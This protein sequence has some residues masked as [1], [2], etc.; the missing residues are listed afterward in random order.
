MRARRISL[1]ASRLVLL[2]S[3]DGAAR[4]A[5][6]LTIG[7]AQGPDLWGML[8]MPPRIRRRLPLVGSNQILY[9]LANLNGLSFG[10][11]PYPTR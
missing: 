10:R 11:T 8:A 4:Y 7:L 5:A 2:A 6:S 3:L 1:R 9:L